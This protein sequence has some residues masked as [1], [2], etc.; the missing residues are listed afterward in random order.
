MKEP[1]IL[2]ILV[3][4]EIPYCMT[5]IYITSANSKFTDTQYSNAVEIS[6]W[7]LDI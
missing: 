6:G 7:S 4:F 2:L 3:A 1:T 5:A